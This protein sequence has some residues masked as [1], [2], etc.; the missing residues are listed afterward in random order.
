MNKIQIIYSRMY[1]FFK[2]TSYLMECHRSAYSR[3]CG[4]NVCG[5]VE[6]SP[7][8]ITRNTDTMFKFKIKWIKNR[9]EAFYRYRIFSAIE[10][11]QL[12]CI[13]RPLRVVF[14]PKRNWLTHTFFLLFS[15]PFLLLSSSSS[16]SS[17]LSRFFLFHFSFL[18]SRI[19]PWLLG[20][21]YNSTSFFLY[22]FF[23][24]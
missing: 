8:L 11:H 24:T 13:A 4:S 12:V 17:S 9:K 10:Y 1:Q 22:I 2:I 5:V 23:F 16:S 7:S 21:L 18:H 19:Q 6:A 15:A 3:E 20:H 14:G